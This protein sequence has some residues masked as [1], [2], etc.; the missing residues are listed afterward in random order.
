MS[1][2]CQESLLTSNSEL[3]PFAA[4]S[5]TLRPSPPTC[6]PPPKVIPHQR[7]PLFLAYNIVQYTDLGGKEYET[8]VRV[9]VSKVKTKERTI[10][11]AGLVVQKVHGFKLV[12]V[13]EEDEEVACKKRKLTA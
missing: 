1:R 13:N 8:A 9:M 2:S 6:L 12:E 3:Q 4:M 10:R 7:H 11:A 5:A